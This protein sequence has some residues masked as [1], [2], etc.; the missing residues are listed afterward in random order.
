[1]LKYTGHPFV[2]VGIA[3]ITAFAGKKNPEQLTIGDLD[4]IADYMAQNYTVKPLRSF[5]T[6][7]F[8]NSGFTQPAYFNKPEEQQKYAENVLRSFRPGVPGTGEVDVFMGAPVPAVSFDVKGGL[9]HGR[10]FRQHIP[11]LTG[12]DVI[13][14]YPN[15]DAGMPVSGEALLAIQ[16]FPLGCAKCDG[17]MLAVHSDNP[18]ITLHFARTFLEENRQIVQ[19]SQ[20]SD[21]IPETHLKFRTLVMDTL[22]RAAQMQQDYKMDERPFSVTVYHVSN[23]GQSPKLD[24]YY[25]PLQVIRFLQMMLS[26]D[27]REDWGKIV[28]RAWELSVEKKG[29]KSQAEETFSPRKNYLY[30]DLFYLPEN[31]RRFL[32]TYFL[33]VVLKTAKMEKGDPR[34]NYSTHDEVEIVSWKITQ[35]FLKRMLHM[36]QDRINKMAQ[37]GDVLAKYVSE[38][39]DKR[40]F[41]DFFREGRYEYF[42]SRLLKANLAHVRRGNPPFLQFDPYIEVFE[43]GTELARPDWRLARDLVLIRMVEQ[44]YQLDWFKKTPDALT[45]ELIAPEQ[46]NG[47]AHS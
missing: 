36:E 44:L 3:T 9:I 19:L 26:A 30:E 13:N 5:L 37:M 17:R 8:P 38:E 29:K 22:L 6:V 31:A 25:L 27:Y 21:R 11:L 32:R 16:A 10:A 41:Q 40:F 43:E 18:E 33:R 34:Q 35:E 2:D 7:A 39:N 12:E 14:F 1:M 15:G 42:R 4:Q 23:F 45:D 20:G 28:N 24:I 46:E 47:N